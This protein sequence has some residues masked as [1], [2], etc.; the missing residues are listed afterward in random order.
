M[1]DETNGQGTSTCMHSNFPGMHLLPGNV[2]ERKL[3]SLEEGVSS[4]R[5]RISS[6]MVFTFIQKNFKSVVVDNALFVTCT[7]KDV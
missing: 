2:F 7:S 1:S 6:L 3:E 4:T 5:Q